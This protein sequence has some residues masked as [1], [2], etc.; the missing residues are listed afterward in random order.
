VALSTVC[1]S[2][3]VKRKSLRARVTK[4]A[5]FSVHHV[6][7]AR[8]GG[9]RIQQ[10]HVVHLRRCDPDKRGDGAAQIEQRVQL[11]RVL[12][13]LVARPGKQRH[14]Q[15]DDGGV[16]GVHR[17]GQ[18]Q[19][20]IFVAIEQPRLRDQDSGEVGIDAPVAAFVGIGQRAARHCA[21][22]AQVIKPPVLRAQASD[23]VAQALAE[24]QL[25]K[26]H[27]KKLVPAG[28]TPHPVVAAVALHTFAKLVDGK[29]VHQLREQR[30]SKIHGDRNSNRSPPFAHLSSDIPLLYN[31]SPNS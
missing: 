1:D 13:R 19:P 11:E 8:L 22:N 17:V 27:A 5:P 9:E 28:E 20:Q 2:S 6:K 26:R 25:G 23:D 24:S 14:A 15:I 7:R 16:Q 18:V 31:R 30:L 29:M 4:N 3:R 10:I 21:P 12:G